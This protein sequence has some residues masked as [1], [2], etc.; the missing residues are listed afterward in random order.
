MDEEEGMTEQKLII[1]DIETPPEIIKTNN[2][3]HPL[4]RRYKKGTW[5][6]LEYD[7]WENVEDT[8]E[9]EEAYQTFRSQPKTRHVSC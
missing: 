8:S 4:Y 3:P 5:S 6:R 2:K 1:Y 9:L 7:Y